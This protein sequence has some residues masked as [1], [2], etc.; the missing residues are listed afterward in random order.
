MASAY[1][2]KV[3]SLISSAWFSILEIAYFFVFSEFAIYSW[4]K[5]AS[6][7]V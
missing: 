6:S 4:V 7:R 2:P 3:D 5:P 1:L